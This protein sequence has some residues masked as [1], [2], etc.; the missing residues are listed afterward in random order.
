M[1]STIAPIDGITYDNLSGEV[2][3]FL[4]TAGCFSILFTIIRYITATRKHLS[5][6]IDDVFFILSLVNLLRTILF[7]KFI[8][9]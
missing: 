6:D 7:I 3:V 2:V 8:L 9:I 5:F 4:I 1:A